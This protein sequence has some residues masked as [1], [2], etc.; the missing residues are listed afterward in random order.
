MYTQF[1]LFTVC[2]CACVRVSII[3]ICIQLD[4]IEFGACSSMQSTITQWK[5]IKLFKNVAPVRF[6][7]IRI[8][9]EH[10]APK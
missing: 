4:I 2:M 10:R 1:A 5:K 8:R 6:V 3:A 7:C 9:F